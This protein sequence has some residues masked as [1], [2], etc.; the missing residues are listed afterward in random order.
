M[1]GV[2]VLSALRQCGRTEPLR[3]WRQLRT[4]AEQIADA[5]KVDEKSG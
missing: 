2:G 3:S 4:G 1:G 5:V